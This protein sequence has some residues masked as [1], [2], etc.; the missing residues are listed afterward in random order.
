VRSLLALLTLL[1]VSCTASLTAEIAAS[2]DLKAKPPKTYA[3]LPFEMKL[4][5]DLSTISIKDAM[6]YPNANTVMNDAFETAFLEGGIRVVERSKLEAA[7]KEAAFANSG[8]TAD[9]GIQLGKMVSAD[10]ILMGTITA[11][12]QGGFGKKPT[13][14]SVSIKTI[15]VETGTILWKGEATFQGPPAGREFEA[16]P[17]KV[18]KQVAKKLIQELLTK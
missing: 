11:Y 8:L 12:H 13:I 9:N 17:S 4:S 5:P 14:V 7:I 18:S 1:L 6:K 10:A 2:P 15:S 16:D 3:M